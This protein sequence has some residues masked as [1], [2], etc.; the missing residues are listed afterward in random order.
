[1]SSIVFERR[2]FKALDRES[3]YL[4]TLNSNVYFVNIGDFSDN[5]L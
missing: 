4:Q 5:Y 3:R 2:Y 1:M